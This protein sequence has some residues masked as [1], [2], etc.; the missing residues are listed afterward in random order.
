MREDEDKIYKDLIY[1]QNAYFLGEQI[2]PYW[3]N[4]FALIVSGFFIVYFTATSLG[5]PEKLV[6]GVLGLI[7]SFNWFRIVT[8]NYLYSQARAERMGDLEKAISQDILIE[9]TE[10][11][12]TLKL[13]NLSE[14]QNKIIT[15]R[16]NYWSKKGTWL[17]R[18]T[19]PKYLLIIWVWLLIYTILCW[20]S[21][22]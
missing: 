20:T 11:K 22:L 9:T 2:Y 1:T 19:A 12:K 13:F 5:Y 18:K 17:L 7:F 15:E 8:R 6:L 3:E 4:I 21:L 14:H 16:E 10:G